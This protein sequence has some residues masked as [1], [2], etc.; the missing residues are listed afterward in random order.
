MSKQ[1]NWAFAYIDLAEF[2]TVRERYRQ[3]DPDVS[4][5][6]ES[7]V[8]QARSILLRPIITVM[9]KPG[10]AASGDKHDF[11]AIGGYSWPNPSTLDGLPFQYR[12]SETNPDALTSPEYDKGS[13]EEMTRQVRLLSLATFYTGN[14]AFASHAL[15]IL[16]MWF[17]DPSTRMNPNFRHAA[18]R[19]GVWD[20]HFSGAIEGVFLIELIDYIALLELSG[21]I[22]HSDGLAIR[23][24]FGDLSD[25]LCTSSFGR[26]EAFSVNN[27]V[28]YLLSQVL[29]FSTF[30]GQEQRSRRAILQARRE[31][32]LQVEKDGRMPLEIQRADGF[33]YSIYGLRAFALLARLAS[34]HG[35]D[36]WRFQNSKL[37]QASL[38]LSIYVR[39]ETRWPFSRGGKEWK[40]DAAQLFHLAA[41]EY[42]TEAL[43]STARLAAGLASAEHAE[44]KLWGVNELDAVPRHLGA[45]QAIEWHD[46]GTSVSRH[47]SRLATTRVLGVMAAR[48]LWRGRYL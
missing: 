20:G 2:E 10:V 5:T 16:R 43:I 45:L 44:V 22:P 26:R 24:W 3:G 7:I 14:Q 40:R 8:A 32:K 41:R 38:S 47:R 48:G 4:T 25:W 42:R 34:A 33:F 21:N 37:E 11:F 46:N 18:A 1:S 17:V 28:S 27:H 15:L 13:Y 19:P 30:A 31:L 35:H 39:D 6:L 12:D 23:S 36:L 29:A 9:D